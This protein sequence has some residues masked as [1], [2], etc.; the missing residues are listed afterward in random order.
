MLTLIV[1]GA[2]RYST[3][4]P[5]TTLIGAGK[6][7]YHPRQSWGSVIVQATRPDP[8]VGVNTPAAE[9]IDRHTARPLAPTWG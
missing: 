5:W 6:P 1:G 4:V 7:E 8:E 3:G 9:I 2:L